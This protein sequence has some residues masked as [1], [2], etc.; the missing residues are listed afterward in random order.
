MMLEFSV[1]SMR[2]LTWSVFI[3]VLL[4]SNHTFAQVDNANDSDLIQSDLHM[5][6]SDY[7]D[8]LIAIIKSKINTIEK[9]QITWHETP[10]VTVRMDAP[11][12]VME[13]H[14]RFRTGEAKLIELASLVYF[15]ELEKF[16]EPIALR[17]D[18]EYSPNS[19]SIGYSATDPASYIQM[20]TSSKLAARELRDLAEQY[21]RTNTI[22]FF[23]EASSV[24]GIGNRIRN[25][26]VKEIV[27]GGMS[28]VYPVN[29]LK[30]ITIFKWCGN[31]AKV[32]ELE[33]ELRAWIV[34]DRVNPEHYK[35]TNSYEAALEEV[36]EKLGVHSK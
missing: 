8:F 1:R 13:L 32:L 6:R 35:I 10:E 26:G 27:D 31:D 33:K 29:V 19:R 24:A 4:Y 28:G 14:M 36:L 5:E 3:A 34:E 17:H 9:I 22:P 12:L 18:L 20:T 16:I 21:L 15:R 25:F 23:K 30:A 2:I 11:T 7:V